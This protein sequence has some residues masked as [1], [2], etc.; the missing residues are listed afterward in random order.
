[1][2]WIH[3]AA[4]LGSVAVISV[5]WLKCALSFKEISQ[6]AW[7]CVINVYGRANIAF[8]TVHRKCKNTLSLT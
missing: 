5:T 8:K 7:C 6:L 2:G 1:M 3:T 4:E